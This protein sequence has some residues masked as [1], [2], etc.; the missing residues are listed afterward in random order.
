[1]RALLVCLVLAVP[2]AAQD[3]AGTDR[4]MERVREDCARI[5]KALEAYLGPK[6]PG[7]VRVELKTKQ[8]LADFARDVTEELT[9]AGLLEVAQRMAVRMKIV[10]EGYDLFGQQ[11]ELLKSQIAGLYDPRK[12]TFYVVKGVGGPGSAPFA[13]TVAHELAHAYRDVDKD[14]YERMVASFTEDADWAMGVQFLVEG[15]ATLIGYAVGFA[16]LQDQDPE[17]FMPMMVQRAKG[18][19]QGMAAQMQ[20]LEGFPYALKEMLV[21][22]YADGMGFA[23]AVFKKGGKE[24]LDKAYG[25]PPRSTEQVLHPEKYLGP[26]VDEPTTFSGGDPTAALGEDW[27]LVFVNVMGEFEARVLFTERLGLD[28]ATFAVD[29]WDGSRYWYCTKD[30][31]PDFLGMIS[32]W[33]STYDARQFMNAWARWASLRDGEDA[34]P[35]QAVIE[36]SSIRDLRVETADGLVVVRR[37]G[38]DVWVA[39]GV[40]PERA[41]EVLEAMTR[42]RRAE[43]AA[44]AHPAR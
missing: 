22:P 8:Q 18:M 3:E 43:R 16:I 20:A 19:R 24:A 11:I 6:F 17:K 10:P 14:Y 33:D 37:D 38:K 40:P 1:M 42:V 32:T 25:N 15:E 9:P 5:S 41:P 34:R 29:G 35:V 26:E 21:A 7:P 36:G 23:A 30:G 27:R 2:A 13:I 28:T 44:T 12:D 39:D 31:A 4:Y